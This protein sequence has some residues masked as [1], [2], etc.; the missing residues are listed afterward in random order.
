M[1]RAILNAV[2]MEAQRAMANIVVTRTGQVTGYD[3]DNY[4]AK[5]ELHPDGIKTDWLP[6]AAAWIG[7]QWGMFAPPNIGDQVTVEFID[8]D[9]NAGTVTSRFWNNQQRPLPVPS[10][11]LW[12]VHASG[13]FFKF[14]NDGKGI[15]SDGQGATITL[16][17]DG[18]IVSQANLWRHNGDVHIAGNVQVDETLTATT[19]VVGGGISLK[20]HKTTLVQPG[21]GLSG[22]P[23]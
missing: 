11:E 9:L 3:P 19:D 8:G 15:F 18:N 2:R 1:M 21:G 5:V 6:I 22:L 10:G 20:N 12:I 17:G 16:D 14:T 23:Q 7:S 13:A 4:A